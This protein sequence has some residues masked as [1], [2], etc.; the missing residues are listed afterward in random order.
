MENN[1]ELR[2]FLFGGAGLGPSFPFPRDSVALA[3]KD[4]EWEWAGCLMSCLGL[5]GLATSVLS[6]SSAAHISHATKSGWLRN[7]QRGHCFFCSGNETTGSEAGSW[8]VG[9]RGG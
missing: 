4:A 9:R 2:E 1:V 5:G 7:V 8:T 3:G 6:G